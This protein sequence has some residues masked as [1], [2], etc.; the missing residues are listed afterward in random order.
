MM[1]D[2]DLP[3]ETLL[4]QTPEELERYFDLIIRDYQLPDNDDTRD[5]VA[6][7]IL[8]LPQTKVYVPMSYF[9]DCVRKSIAN[10]VAFD[11]LQIFKARREAA[12]EAK[13]Q[14]EA[15]P[16]KDSSE[17]EQPIQDA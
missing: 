13:K 10:K 1:D 6:T 2:T 5:A 15:E 17:P 7:M 12:A 16:K 14:A 4:P 3:P 11:Q 8:H 9:A